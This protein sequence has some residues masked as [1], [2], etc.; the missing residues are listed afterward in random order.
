LKEKLTP[1]VPR[2][3]LILKLDH[4]GDMLWATPCFAALKFKYPQA[5]IQVI[6][7][8]ALEPVLRHNPAVDQVLVYDRR[9]FSSSRQK[10]EWLRQNVGAPDW[11]ICLDTRDEAVLLAYLS[12]APVRIGYYYKDRPFSTIKSWWRLTHKF[13][14]P[15]M[16]QNPRHEVLNNLRLLERVGMLSLAELPAEL[17]A[18]RLYLTPE[19]QRQA[20]TVFESLG[21]TNQPVIMYNIPNKTINKG[22]PKEHITQVVAELIAH[23]PGVQIV[24]VAGPGEEPLLESIRPALPAACRTLTGLPL[25][26]WAGLFSYCAFSLSRDAGGVHVSAAMGVPA[27]SIFEYEWQHLEACFEPWQVP[28]INLI[29]PQSPTPA[30]VARHVE[31]I[32]TAAIDLWKKVSNAH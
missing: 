5:K 16:H 4:L 22:W 26:I 24:M 31:T 2:N 6:C 7:P 3:I 29:R 8:A 9:L 10:Q 15:T 12:G 20:G 14:H 25:R 17:L 32:V 1:K 27:I 11:A 23:I 18:T 19:E 30:N 13:V 28:H 21:L